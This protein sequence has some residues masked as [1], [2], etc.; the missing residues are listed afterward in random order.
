MISEQAASCTK[1]ECGCFRYFRDPIGRASERITPSG[2]NT[3]H[4]D[5][6]YLSVELVL[7]P[8]GK[9][10]CEMLKAALL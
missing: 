9:A 2:C 1:I 4:L 8:S 5:S 10:L 7:S 6:I 3:C